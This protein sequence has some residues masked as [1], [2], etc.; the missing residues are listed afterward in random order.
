MRPCATSGVHGTAD[1]RLTL[2]TRANGTV[3]GSEWLENPPPW[4]VS[5]LCHSL[6]AN[7]PDIPGTWEW[8]CEC[9]FESMSLS[10]PVRSLAEN[11]PDVTENPRNS[12]AFCV[13][14]EPETGTISGFCR[15]VS[16]F[17]PTSVFLVPSRVPHI[18]GLSDRQPGIDQRRIAACEFKRGL[19]PT[20]VGVSRGERTGLPSPPSTGPLTCTRLRRE[21]STH[22]IRDFRGIAPQRIILYTYNAPGRRGVR[23][24]PKLS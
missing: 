17:S 14:S 5:I 20:S 7:E 12:R 4:T 1:I 21:K 8:T 2:S 13:H 23:S 18:S 15:L 3:S 16:E 6:R 24:S 9:R 11:W 22:V 10:H 19:K